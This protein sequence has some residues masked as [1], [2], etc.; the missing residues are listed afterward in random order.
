MMTTTTRVVAIAGVAVAVLGSAVALASFGWHGGHNE[1]F[2]RR[3]VDA[4]V[5][6]TLDEI[7]AT[8]QQRQ[9]VSAIEDRLLADFQ[10][11]RDARRTFLTSLTDQFSQP[12][13]DNASIEQAFQPVA[14]SHEKLRQ[15]LLQTVGDLH[16]LLTPDQRAKLVERVR[17]LQERW[18]G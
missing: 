8:P 4:H 9:K 5:E 6:E 11:S 12:Q 1:K 13:L 17:H 3:M 10:V 2:M 16:D 7:N 14:Q 15:E 18:G